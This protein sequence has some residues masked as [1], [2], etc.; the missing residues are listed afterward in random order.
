[1]NPPSA[2]VLTSKDP[3]ESL[4]DF[5]DRISPIVVKELRQGLRQPSFVILFL[6][7]QSVLALAV[8]ASLFSVSSNHLSSRLAMGNMISGF[9]FG[10]FSL[11]VLVIQPLR[12]LGALSTEIRDSTIDLLLLTRLDA[13]RIVFGKWLCLVTQSGLL[14]LAILPYLM[15]RYFLGGMNLLAELGSLASLFLV[16]AMIC[17]GGVGISVIRSVILRTIFAIAGVI[18][19]L[20]LFQGV[21]V[22]FAFSRG[23][24]SGMGLSMTLQPFEWVIIISASVL[25]NAFLTYNFLEFGA[26]RIAPPSENRSTRKRLVALGALLII[27]TLFIIPDLDSRYVSYLALMIIGPLTMADALSENP[28]FVHPIHPRFNLPFLRP[29]W[30]SGAI[31]SILMVILI[32]IWML[33]LTVVMA[34]HHGTEAEMQLRANQAVA[35]CM[36]M[37]VQPS[38]FLALFRP[39][40]QEPSNTYLT[41]LLGSL[42]LGMV[43]LMIGAAMDAHELVSS[44]MFPVFPVLGFGTLEDPSL[45]QFL[46]IF[47]S[48]IIYLI[49]A[50]VVGNQKWK[51]PAAVAMTDP[52][53]E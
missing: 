20:V 30:P 47:L 32:G 4:S 18:G 3:I 36:L 26:T 39:R 31:Y 24:R 52:P 35:T 1:M 38:L 43:L 50:A 42:A 2:P 33:L 40:D 28:R 29:G 14:L 27:P 53:K 37:I 12:A 19:F 22:L 15:M 16:G 10:L 17:A 45:G 46:M 51:Y 23:M 41:C 8:I 13:W 21:G 44:L 5:P 48:S 6:F 25:L 11:A 49:G 9:F 7:L 34:N